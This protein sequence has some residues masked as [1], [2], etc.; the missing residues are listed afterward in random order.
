MIAPVTIRMFGML[1]S[2][3]TE[4]GLAPI[5]EM[6]PPATGLS[7][8]DIAHALDLPVDQIEGVF[9]NHVV[10]GLDHIVMPGD[11]IAF[12][13]PGTPGPHR[14]LLGLYGAEKA[15]TADTMRTPP[16]RE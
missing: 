14:F 11:R 3:R 8:R 1:R 5:S 16:A 12:V 10:R 7:A 2:A 4:R 13:P 9:V 6:T 15:L